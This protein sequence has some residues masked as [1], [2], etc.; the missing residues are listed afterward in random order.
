MPK[1][2]VKYSAL[3]KSIS[4]EL[5]ARKRVLSATQDTAQRARLEYEVL[6]M[7]ELTLLL[8]TNPDILFNPLYRPSLYWVG[9]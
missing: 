1:S 9:N 8:R 3:L 6:Q 5:E 7:T 2:D 4:D